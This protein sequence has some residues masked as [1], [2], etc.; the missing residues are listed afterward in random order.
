MTIATLS[1]LLY[2]LLTIAGG[3]IGYLSSK[4]KVSLMMGGSLGMVVVVGAIASFQGQ[5]VGLT[6]ATILTGLLVVVFVIRWLKTKKLMPAGLMAGLGLLALV[7][8]VWG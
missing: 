1:A 5:P 7:L 2:G 8:M 6:V 4:S 3:I